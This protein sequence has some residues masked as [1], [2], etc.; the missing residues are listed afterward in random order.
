MRSIKSFVLL[1]I[2]SLAIAI[3]AGKAHGYMSDEEAGSYYQQYREAGVVHNILIVD[4]QIINVT[5]GTDF[6]QMTPMARYD[7]A[8][9]LSRAH[10]GK[11]ISVT[12]ALTGEQ[13]L[14][15][16]GTPER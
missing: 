2:L 7:F 1:A 15:I 8:V 3:M 11:V 10:S 5:V 12:D 13:F 9:F 16:L 14:E 4:K 6:N